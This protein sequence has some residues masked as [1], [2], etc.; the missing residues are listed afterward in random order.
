[1]ILIRLF[2]VIA[3]IVVAGAFIGYFFS[4]NRRLLNFGVRALQMALLLFLIMAGFY[5]IERLLI[6]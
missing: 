3:V 5:I 6:L 2:V 4:G 1:M